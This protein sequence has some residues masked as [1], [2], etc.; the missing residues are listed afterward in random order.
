MK[1]AA[2]LRLA[3]QVEPAESTMTSTEAVAGSLSLAAGSEGTVERAET[4]A[5]EQSRQVREYLRLKSLLDDFG[6]HM[7]P[8]SRQQLEEQVAALEA[9]WIAHLK[10][11]PRMRLR[12]RLDNGFILDEADA[13]LFT[14]C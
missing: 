12:V 13:T 6:S 7:P 1:L 3:G 11:E 8:G 5:L 9:H 10:A 14:P 4:L 2:D